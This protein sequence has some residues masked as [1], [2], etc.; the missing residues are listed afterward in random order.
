[1]RTASVLR[2]PACASSGP[3]AY[4]GLRDGLYASQGSW[5][6]RRCARCRTLWLDPQPVP[7]DIHL[8]YR[9]YHTHGGDDDA[10]TQRVAHRLTTLLRSAYVDERYGYSTTRV[11]ALVRKLLAL[12]IRGW[13]GQRAEAD[14]AVALTPAGDPVTMLDIGC[15]GG[16]AVAFARSLGW[17]AAGIDPDPDAVATARRRGIRADVGELEAQGY[18]TGKFDLIVM[19]HVIEHVHDPQ[20]LLQECRRILAVGGRVL[21]TTP[22]VGSAL[23]L[24]YREH[25]RGLE[26][27]R[28]LRIYSVAGLASTLQGAGLTTGLLTTTARGAAYAAI[29]SR[30]LRRGR[31]PDG[32]VASARERAVA[33]ILQA[34]LAIRL[35]HDLHSGQE[36]LAL[37]TA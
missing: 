29:G 10:S 7:E 12:S 18:P 15:G 3:V 36:I 24:R 2:C 11:P 9:R 4:S 25:W 13:A 37:A 20:R 5:Q 30:A 22:N 28:H 23:H 21:I 26:P 35:R 17:D 16:S 32:L 27:P 14:V 1:M 31:A 6:F 8:A 19:N 33:E 34:G